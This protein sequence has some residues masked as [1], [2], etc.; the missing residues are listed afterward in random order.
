MTP[1]YDVYFYDTELCDYSSRI[2]KYNLLDAIN[3]IQYFMRL[4]DISYLY[5]DYYE[6]NASMPLVSHSWQR[7]DCGN[8]QQVE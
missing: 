1:F 5:L 8:W 6:C 2:R 4:D 7:I 3:D